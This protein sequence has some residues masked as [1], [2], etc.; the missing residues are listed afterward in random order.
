M[1]GPDAEVGENSPELVAKFLQNVRH[2]I[3][4]AIEQIDMMLR[5]V[6]AARGDRLDRFLDL[7]CGDGLLSS[8]LLDD[9]PQARGWLVDLSPSLLG[10]ARK[11][12]Q[13]NSSVQFISADFARPSWT[14]AVAM[15]APFDAIVSALSIHALPDAR[16][17]GLYREI[18]DLLKPEGVFIAI[19]HVASATR[20]TESI[21]ADYMIDAI[22]GQA[23]K[24][25][26][27]KTRVEIAREYYERGG[28]TDRP[29][30]PLEVQCDWL[31]GL[32]FENVDCYL[33]V[34]ELAVFGGQRPAAD[35]GPK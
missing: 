5:L 25:A 24:A 14:S 6:H 15:G 29:L 4:L 35:P 19:E 32:G 3:P 9:Y 27:G 10:G 12:L 13:K 16:K 8:A 31:R 2:S 1:T 17:R 23:I 21:W 28:Q 22:F 20:W 34:L 11:Q 7:G 30:A 26:P 18:F 33:K